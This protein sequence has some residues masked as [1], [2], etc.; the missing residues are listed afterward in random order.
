MLLRDQ[1]TPEVLHKPTR[2]EVP[3][4]LVIEDDCNAAQLIQSYLA[5]SG[6]ETVYCDQPQN[7]MNIVAEL[8]PD[9]ITLDLLM[10][11]S[12]GWEVLLRLKND[13]RTATIPVV[14]ISI[15]DQPAIGTTFGADEYLVKPIDKA[16]LLAAVGR[17]L[18]S[19]SSSR[20]SPS[21]RP[22]LV[23]EDDTPT[24][25]IIAEL[26]TAHGYTVSLA[27]DG[28]QARDHVAESLPEL[29]ILDLILPKASG[30]ELLAEWRAKPRTADLPVFVLTSKDLTR[31]EEQY[32]RKH[33]ESLFHKQQSW[34]Q[35]LT[36]QLRRALQ[37]TPTVRS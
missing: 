2:G 35:A 9:V 22:I 15:V 1:R 23:V 7:A 37:N 17:C 31:E 27:E 13:P 30:F 21:Q 20:R 36:E 3:K 4:V 12:S 6:Y 18:S 28:E 5:S 19:S 33:A 11:P 8:Q 34:Q 14:V 10:N 29:V 26:L 25:E 24:R 32:L 16:A